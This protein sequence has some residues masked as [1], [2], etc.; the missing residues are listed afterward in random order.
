MIFQDTKYVLINYEDLS[1]FK[2]EETS[3]HN[4][5]E[6]YKFLKL[7]DALQVKSKFSEYGVYSYNPN[8]SIYKF[9]KEG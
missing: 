6:A 9:K 2:D 7:R 8:L 4:I 5:D 1:Y 3:T